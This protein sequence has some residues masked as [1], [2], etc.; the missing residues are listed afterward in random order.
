M[1]LANIFFDYTPIYPTP[2]PL[3]YN[4]HH[5]IHIHL[6]PPPKYH[7]HTVQVARVEGRYL[8]QWVEGKTPLAQ[9]ATGET[10]TGASGIFVPTSE[11]DTPPPE[12]AAGDNHCKHKVHRSGCKVQHQRKSER[13]AAATWN[14]NHHH[15]R[16]AQDQHRRWWSARC[17]NHCNLRKGTPL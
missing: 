13:D 16:P 14:S 3:R 9:V 10:T 6:P 7:H 5:H 17:S 11:G 12:V 2:P 8:C 4:H 15:R 1:L